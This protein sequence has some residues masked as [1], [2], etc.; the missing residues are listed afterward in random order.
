MALIHIQRYPEAAMN[1]LLDL[2][3]AIARRILSWP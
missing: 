3:C 1:F 2:I